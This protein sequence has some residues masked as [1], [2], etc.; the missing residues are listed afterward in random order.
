MRSLRKSRTVEA[1]IEPRGLH[2]PEKA[3][4]IRHLLLDRR[5]SGSLQSQEDGVFVVIRS[6]LLMFWRRRYR[7]AIG[8]INMVMAIRA[9]RVSMSL[10][11]E[12]QMRTRMFCWL[13]VLVSVGQHCRRRQQK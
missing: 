13:I 4:R 1:H 11:C 12:M 2:Q 3:N 6:R 5:V 8:F 9:V 7:R 10:V